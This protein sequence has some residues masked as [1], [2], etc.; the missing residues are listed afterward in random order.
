MSLLPRGKLAVAIGILALMGS[1]NAA[2]QSRAVAITRVLIQTVGNEGSITIDADGPLPAPTAGTLDSPPRIF[3]DFAGVVTRVPARTNSTDP[4][5]LRVRVALNRASP[6]TTRVVID[7]AAPLPHHVELRPR[8]VVMRFG[9]GSEPAPAPAV[10]P[11]S[12]P[13]GTPLPLPPPAPPLPANNPASGSAIAPVPDLPPATPTTP[14]GPP[15]STTPIPAVPA[16]PLALSTAVPDAPAPPPA[17]APPAPRSYRVVGPPPLPRDI[18]KYKSLAGG[19]IDRLRLQ[20]PLIEAVD[21]PAAMPVD[22]L[23]LAVNELDRIQKDLAGVDAPESVRHQHELFVQAA[24][25][26]YMALTLRMEAAA[27]PADPSAAR[28]AGAAAAGALLTLERACADLGFAPAPG[29]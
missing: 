23:Q 26:G 17:S 12:A 19:M 11:T 1:S 7:L 25:L 15:T 2:G 21:S 3:F 28:N 24:R 16:D 14:S 22:R 10:S 8:Q 29:R 6:P 27:N 18:E 4:R 20:Q 13:T 9:D 5:I